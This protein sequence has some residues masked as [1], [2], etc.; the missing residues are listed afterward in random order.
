MDIKTIKLDNS[1][2]SKPIICLIYDQSH[3]ETNI[4]SDEYNNLVICK[5]KIDELN[6]HKT[7]DKSKK[8]SNDY[9]L[10][11]LPNKKI[12]NKSVARY[13]PLSRSY[14]KLW[15]II[16]DFDLLNKEMWDKE[17]KM[18]GIAE[19]PGGFIEA[20]INYR[21]K[22][23]D[24]IDKVYGITLKST[25]KDIPGWKKTKYFLSNNP[26]ITISY[27]T[28]DTGNIYNIDNI[29]HFLKEVGK[30]EAD[31]ITADGG[32]DFSIDF[33]KQELLAYKMIFCE[34]VTAL[35]VQKKGGCFICKIFDIYTEI[36]IQFIYLLGYLYKDIYITKPFTSRPANSEKYIVCKN[37]K[38]IDDDYLE[39]LQIL[40]KK[41]SIIDDINYHVNSIFK[42]NKDEILEQ[43]LKYN[44][45]NS[46]L[47]IENI[48][49][50][51]NIIKN[52]GKSS[53][54]N[55]IVTN[56]NNK[57]LEWCKKYEVEIN[58]TRD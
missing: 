37:F 34:I 23:F 29:L 8:L 6:D 5:N 25:N 16:Y 10:I 41:W 21:K 9:E 46:N 38:G 53:L 18:C 11:Y 22:H 47:Q 40:I 14:F 4:N 7:W 17:V 35:S 39:Q 2:F 26:Q 57:A 44:K 52:K 24:Y 55:Q 15:E 50:T 48:N 36:T 31:F 1:K 28:D 13:D 20:F 12:K 58:K 45:S 27:G 33:N 56:Q 43:I 51:L 42:I 49:K 19:G 3:T 54:Y 32:F 30:G